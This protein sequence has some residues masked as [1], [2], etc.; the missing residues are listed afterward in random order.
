MICL[1]KTEIR[2]IKELFA[3]L[4]PVPEALY[5]FHFEIV[6]LENCIRIIS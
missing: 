5:L 2:V 6:R 4:G 3:Y 1:L